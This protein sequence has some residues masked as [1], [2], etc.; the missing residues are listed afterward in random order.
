MR[1]EKDEL[2]K[3]KQLLDRTIR[4]L[5]NIYR[6]KKKKT[7]PVQVIS[8]I[9]LLAAGG[10][11]IVSSSSTDSVLNGGI[12]VLGALGIFFGLSVAFVGY[13]VSHRGLTG[14]WL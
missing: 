13:I 4:S 2:K 6:L 12:T 3:Y 7:S 14:H 5:R 9:L 11:I 1:R 8:G 10:R